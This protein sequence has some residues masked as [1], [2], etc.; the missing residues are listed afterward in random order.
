MGCV[1]SEQEFILR[2]RRLKLRLCRGP[3]ARRGTRRGPRRGASR[4][5]PAVHGQRHGPG[6][7][8]GDAPYRRR[9][10]RP[11]ASEGRRPLRCTVHASE[12]RQRPERPRHATADSA[13]ADS[14]DS[15]AAGRPQR[16]D[17]QPSKGLG[18][19]G[20]T[21]A[22]AATTTTEVLLLLS[23]LLLPRRRLLFPALLKHR[24]GAAPGRHRLCEVGRPVAAG[25]RHVPG[26]ILPSMH[27]HKS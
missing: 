13:A 21:A 7:L 16:L 6:L 19:R 14:N 1:G 2:Q 8:P 23:L 18:A 3:R 25:T 15:A 5:R 26:A 11:A 12:R 17:G 24:L 27:V 4:Q 10:G 20:A 9:G 22:V